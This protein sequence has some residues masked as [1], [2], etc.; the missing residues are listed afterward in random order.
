MHTVYRR[1]CH[2]SGGL[3]IPVPSSTTNLSSLVFQSTRMNRA[4]GQPLFLQNL[5]CH[6]IDGSRL[7]VDPS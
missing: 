1:T 6:C 7:F 4:P 5:N 2:Y 3:P